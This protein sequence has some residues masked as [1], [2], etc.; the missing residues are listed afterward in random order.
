MQQT[1]QGRRE[2]CGSRC[3][4]NNVTILRRTNDERA[5]EA[6]FK[7][8][9]FKVQYYG[10]VVGN[11]S[12]STVLVWTSVCG[13]FDSAPTAVGQSSTQKTR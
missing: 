9:C 10:T 5:E 4:S 7:G 11:P 2:R 6:G 3:L 13:Q 12:T 1:L 8:L